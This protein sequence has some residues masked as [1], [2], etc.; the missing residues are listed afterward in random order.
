MCIQVPKF[1]TQK[2]KEGR[3]AVVRVYGP[4]PVLCGACVLFPK[5]FLLRVG[6]AGRA[7]LQDLGQ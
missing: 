3:P 1:R 5:A 2:I 4:A 7:A 6:K